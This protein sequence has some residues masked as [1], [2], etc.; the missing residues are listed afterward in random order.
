MQ[1][2]TQ[3]DV[4]SVGDKDMTCRV[5]SIVNGENLE[6]APEERMGWIGNLDLLIEEDLI[7]VV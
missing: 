7:G 1:F 5:R 2:N 6:T 4:A 3:G